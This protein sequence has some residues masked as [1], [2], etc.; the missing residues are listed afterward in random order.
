M[1]ARPPFLKMTFSRRALFMLRRAAL[2]FKWGRVPKVWELSFIDRMRELEKTGLTF[3]E[4]L[5]ST[6]P[7]F[8]GEDPS[9]VLRSW[10]GRKAGCNPERFARSVSEMFG[11]S[12]RSVLSSIDVL[13]DEESLLE[14]KVPKEPPIQ[15]LLVAMQRAIA[16][17][18][19]VQP[20]QPQGRP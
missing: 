9:Q 7:Q 14:A 3:D 17:K 20:S 12:A 5:Q 6:L 15:S 18:T 10:I 2:T 19:I 11:A 13:V 4:I 8:L 1:K 16:N